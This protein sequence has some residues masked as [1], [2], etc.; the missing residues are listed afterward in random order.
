[1]RK[2]AG[3]DARASTA[4]ARPQDLNRPHR[5]VTADLMAV[6]TIGDPAPD[7]TLPDSTGAVRRLDD[8]LGERGL[9]LIFYRGHW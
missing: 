1:M 7:L 3:S 4:V 5:P 2:R 6:P 9:V 8:L